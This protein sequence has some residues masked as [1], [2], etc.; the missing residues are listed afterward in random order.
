MNLRLLMVTP[1]RDQDDNYKFTFDDGN[2]KLFRAE[3]PMTKK[4]S[5]LAAAFSSA[6]RSHE[7]VWIDGSVKDG[8]VEVEDYSKISIVARGFRPAQK[9]Y[10]IKKNFGLQEKTE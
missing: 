2:G 3:H 8:T 7:D 10:Q 6:L 4:W 1:L 9:T 5:E